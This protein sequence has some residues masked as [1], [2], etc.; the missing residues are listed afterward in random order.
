MKAAIKVYS[1]ATMRLLLL[2]C[3]VL[4]FYCLDLTAQLQ[5]SWPT[6]NEYN[7]Q[8]T[9]NIDTASY[10]VYR[11]N[12]DF[13]YEEAQYEESN[14]RR[15]WRRFWSNLFRALGKGFNSEIF[16]YL[17][18]IL[19]AAAVIYFLLRSQFSSVLKKDEGKKQGYVEELDIRVS[20]NIL[21]DKW[22]KAKQNEDWRSAIRYAYLISIKKL[23]EKKL[24]Q[25]KEWKLS[26]DYVSDLKGTEWKKEFQEM[27]QFFNYSWY[28]QGALQAK[29][30]Q[31]FEQIHSNFHTRLKQL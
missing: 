17:I 20:E 27:T 7:P 30:F 11:N 13:Q 28:G 31:E 4:L 10:E 21:E 25:W 1:P 12:P 8:Y 3:A 29:G 5:D 18:I 22:Q 16:Q 15:L 23:D 26:E 6:F 14:L 2:T 9:R 24:I 19:A